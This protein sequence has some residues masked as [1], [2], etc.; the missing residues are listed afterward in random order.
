[1]GDGPYWSRDGGTAHVEPFDELSLGDA[2][3]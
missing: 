2:H 1:M 3:P